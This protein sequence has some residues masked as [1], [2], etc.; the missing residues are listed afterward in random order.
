MA[1]RLSPY[2]F[3]SGR[4]WGTG[5]CKPKVFRVWGRSEMRCRGNDNNTAIPLNYRY[6]HRNRMTHFWR[7]VVNLQSFLHNE[8]LK[9]TDCSTK[10]TLISD[11]NKPAHSH[12]NSQHRHK[13][14]PHPGLEAHHTSV[15][16]VSLHQLSLALTH[17]PLI[18]RNFV[19][20]SIS[21]TL[22]IIRTATHWYTVSLPQYVIFFG[23][24]P[25][26]L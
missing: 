10:H 2:S 9:Q 20:T 8:R 16:T 21:R 6:F 22:C 18:N 17:T 1:H 24:L 3:V 26:N 23:H 11:I 25:F 19:H 12:C 5:C 15:Q 14:N 4:W 7:A 13:I